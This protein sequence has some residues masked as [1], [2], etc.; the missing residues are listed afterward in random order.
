MN[1]WKKINHES[2]PFN[3]YEQYEVK[4]STISEKGPQN[5]WCL[6]SE[7][8]INYNLQKKTIKIT[9]SKNS[10]I[11]AMMLTDTIINELPDKIK[12]IT[13]GKTEIS[14]D[15]HKQT[16]EFEKEVFVTIKLKNT[17]NLLYN[18]YYEI[19]NNC[20]KDFIKQIE[21]W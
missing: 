14:T 18:I 11:K 15:I 3:K 21:N 6:N 19:I 1:K 16:K 7:I 2:N 9:Y 12:S 13:L 17:T 5:Q 8:K 4:K 20:D 10:L